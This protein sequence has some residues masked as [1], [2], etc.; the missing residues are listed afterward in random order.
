MALKLEVRAGSEEFSRYR[1][2]VDSDWNKAT[3]DAVLGLLRRVVTVPASANRQAEEWLALPAA[4]GERNRTSA[5]PKELLDALQML[6]SV[7]RV[8]HVPKLPTELVFGRSRLAEQA[9]AAICY[10]LLSIK[11]EPTGES[12]LFRD[13]QSLLYLT[14]VHYLLPQLQKSESTE[15]YAA[16]ANGLAIHP[17][18]VWRDQPAHMFYLLAALMGALGSEEMR[19]DCLEKALSNTPIDDHSY[20]TKANAYWGELL[21]QGQ[22]DK[23][24]DFLLRLSRSMPERYAEEVG[25]MIKE[26]AGFQLPA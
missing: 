20:L 16:L 12:G 10:L 14:A 11:F 9:K 8:P 22:T 19:L 25:E 26:T 15:E 17:V 21:E 24:L 5:V 1:S 4:V 6:S 3:L 2:L 18:L 13:L 7:F 23:A